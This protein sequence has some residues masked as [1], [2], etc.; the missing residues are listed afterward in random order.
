MQRYFD[1][2][3][4]YVSSTGSGSHS[5]L[6]SVLPYAYR[7]LNGTAPQYLADELQRVADISSRSRLR[8]A[9]VD[10]ATS[11]STVES[12]NNRWSGLP[13]RCRKGLEQSAAV[14]NVVAVVTPV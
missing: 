14:D 8:S 9:C 2:W 11:R 4:M 7:C 1:M 6:S 5:G 10:G 3:T 12:Q 13:R